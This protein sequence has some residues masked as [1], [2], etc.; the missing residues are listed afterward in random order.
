[1][2]NA[3]IIV[4]TQGSGRLPRFWLETLLLRKGWLDVTSYF[5]S[6]IEEEKPTRVVLPVYFGKADACIV[7]RHT[8]AT[9]CE[10]NPQLEKRLVPVATSPP[11]LR[12]IL[13]FL[14]GCSKEVREAL[15][16]FLVDLDMRA[17]PVTRQVSLLFRVEDMVPF[18][19]S[20]LDTVLAL[21]KEHDE[22][23]VRLHGRGAPGK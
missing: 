22:R 5:G 7:T 8:F 13:C 21:V 10:L 17:D 12:G 4:R 19:V 6:I 23:K 18:K 11:L 3:R 14:P 2:R 9:L 15:Y 16:Q 1:M 20:Y